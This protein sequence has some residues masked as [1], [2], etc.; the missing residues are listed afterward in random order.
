MR[1]A[2]GARGAARGIKKGSRALIG[3]QVAAFDE[4][5]KRITNNQQG[6]SNNQVNA[7]RGDSNLGVGHSLLGVGH[8]SDFDLDTPIW[9]P[10]NE[11]SVDYGLLYA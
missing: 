3:A 8:S 5:G 10:K 4:R 6:M 2:A 1:I 7:F 9:E 11:E